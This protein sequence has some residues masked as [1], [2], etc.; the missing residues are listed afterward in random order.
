M[1]QAF[2]QFGISPRFHNPLALLLNLCRCLAL[3]IFKLPNFVARVHPER[4]Q[5]LQ[6]GGFHYRPPQHIP[7][8]VRAFA[9]DTPLFFLQPGLL[10]AQLLQL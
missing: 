8:A 1:L 10:L 2:Q 7:L 9:L 6:F 5:V 3:S 4:V